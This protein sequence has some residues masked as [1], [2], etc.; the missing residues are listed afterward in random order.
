MQAVNIGYKKMNRP[1]TTLPQDHKLSL[2]PWH[3]FNLKEVPYP[4]A[5]D[6]QHVL[7]E[8]VRKGTIDGAI[9]MLTHPPTIT[10]GR[11]AN[12]AHIINRDL[13]RE[14][15]WQIHNVDRG[16]DVTWHGPGQLVVYPIIPLQTLG[17]SVRT[18]ICHLSDALRYTLS[19]YGITSHWEDET[20]GV[21]VGRDK[22]AAIGLRISRRVSR[23][24]IA[25][26]ISPDLAA[27]NT[28]VPCGIQTRGV[29]S[30]QRI[31]DQVPPMHEVR[32]ILLG[33]LLKAFGFSSYVTW[34]DLDLG[35]QNVQD[36]LLSTSN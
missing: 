31:L 3:V 17:L 12:P 10:M 13:L 11:H 1:F 21:W 8:C 29:T 36:L 18:L 26:N 15:G 25:L 20:P 23:H 34:E 4:L 7:H 9:M 30:M 6:A 5:L 19:A 22:I 35:L 16:G 27:Y 33:H 2:M 24:G 14:R 28:I 32:E